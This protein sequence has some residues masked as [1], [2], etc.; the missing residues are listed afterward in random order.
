MEEI[1]NKLK[2]LREERNKYYSLASNCQKLI[3][4]LELDLHS[5]PNFKNEYVMF[6]VD[7]ITTIFGKIKDVKRLYSGI[8]LIF[9]TQLTVSGD[10]IKFEINNEED[11]SYTKIKEI[12]I[13]DKS[14]YDAEI[15]DTFEFIKQK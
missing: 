9:D 6:D 5:V 8:R 7:D 11:I 15:L 10:Y 2:Q 14:R 12:S 13:I 4:K 1:S 3:D